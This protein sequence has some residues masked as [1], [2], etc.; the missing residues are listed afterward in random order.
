MVVKTS[1]IRPDPETSEF[2]EVLLQGFETPFGKRGLKLFGGQ[3]QRLAIARAV[4]GDPDLLIFDDA[5]S[6]LGSG[7]EA[8]V[9]SALRAA[10]KCCTVAQVSHYLSSVAGY[11]SVAVLH[12]WR[13]TELGTGADLFAR[14]G[15][16]AELHQISTGAA[17]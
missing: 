13:V 3:Q 7:S 14:G 15:R 2:V 9:Q 11:D 8:V 16:Y 4:L 12:E 17:S 10:H 5:T 1:K 6:A